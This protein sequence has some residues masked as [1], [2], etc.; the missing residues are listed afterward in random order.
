M[1]SSKATLFDQEL[2]F[3]AEFHKVLSHPARLAI[4]LYLAKSNTCIT[5]DISNHFPL[6]RTTINQHLTELKKLNL[7]KGEICGSKVEYC[8]NTK[9]I[10]SLKIKTLDFLNNLIV[11]FDKSCENTK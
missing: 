4:L 1:T 2:Q 10:R 6:A 9:V 11:D 3:Q 5:G 8:L 7:I